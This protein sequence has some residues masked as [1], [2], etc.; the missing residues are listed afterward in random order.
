MINNVAII[1]SQ[2]SDFR[3]TIAERDILLRFLVFSSRMTAWLLG[4]KNAS[5]TAIERWQ[6]LMRQLALTAKLLRTG[7]FVQQF[8]IAAKALRRKH[9]DYFLAYLT[10]IRQLLMA[11]YLTCDNATILNSIGF[12]P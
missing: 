1:A 7:R 6:I 3:F 12:V 5:I 2:L 4:Q 9:Q 10:I 11:V 8:N